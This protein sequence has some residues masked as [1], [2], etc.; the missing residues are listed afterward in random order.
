MASVNHCPAIE[1][2]D[3]HE[4]R[5]EVESIRRGQYMIDYFWC[6]GVKS[7]PELLTALDLVER[8]RNALAMME[9]R[10]TAVAV[11]NRRT[12]DEAIEGHGLG[13]EKS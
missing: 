4:W 5:R 8:A 1:P 6:P 10:A 11:S 3:S 9:A 7:S 12:Y 13:R 2:H